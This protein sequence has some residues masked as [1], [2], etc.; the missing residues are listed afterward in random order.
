MLAE[1]FFKKKN[2]SRSFF[3]VS[4]LLNPDATER[5]THSLQEKAAPVIDAVPR[6]VSG[7]TRQDDSNQVS[8]LSGDARTV[9]VSL[10]FPQNALHKNQ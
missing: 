3:L 9:D 1:G 8:F 7:E 6:Y 2:E 10:D 4:G 5:P